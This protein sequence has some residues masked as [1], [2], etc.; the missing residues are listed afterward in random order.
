MKSV[1]NLTILAL[2]TAAV[3][4]AAQSA[5]VKDIQA[6]YD[7]QNALTIKKDGAGIRQSKQ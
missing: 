3:S 6:F 4:S 2:L 1:A 7:K 5:P